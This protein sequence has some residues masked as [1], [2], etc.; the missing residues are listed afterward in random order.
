MI[1][2]LFV[3]FFAVDLLAATFVPRSIALGYPLVGPFGSKNAI[4]VATLVYASD[5][6]IATVP[7][8]HGGRGRPRTPRLP[9][10]ATGRR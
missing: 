2:S 6:K 1:L 5:R 8:H 7:L 4:W 3:G 10:F 9:R